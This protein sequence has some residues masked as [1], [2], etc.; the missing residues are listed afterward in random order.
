ML[1]LIGAAK[2]GEAE[3]RETM[4]V[5]APIT[6]APSV[7]AENLVASTVEP[8]AVVKEDEMTTTSPIV[9]AETPKRP[10]TP[11]SWSSPRHSSPTGPS[12]PSDAPI[13]SS[14][15]KA[16]G[17]GPLLILEI[18]KLPDTPA[19]P[20]FTQAN[21]YA[22]SADGFIERGM[23]PGWLTR[24]ARRDSVL[25]RSP[26]GRPSLEDASAAEVSESTDEGRDERD[27]NGNLLLSELSSCSKSSKLLLRHPIVHHGTLANRRIE[28]EPNS[29]S[30]VGTTAQPFLFP[31]S[32]GKLCHPHHQITPPLLTKSQ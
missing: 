29:P 5:P 3:M 12:T 25:A 17:K 27:G 20:P 13:T 16:K 10:D 23:V 2:L 21:L 28:H 1:A 30:A 32:G 18:P 4:R 8:D 14:S 6:A 26:E 9:V 7:A 31:F 19:P 24:R 15:A 22:T 11:A